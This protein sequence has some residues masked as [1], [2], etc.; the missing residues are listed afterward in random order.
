MITA[1]LPFPCVYGDAT[2]D[3]STQ[4]ARIE[5]LGGCTPPGAPRT[6]R[7]A[8]RRFTPAHLADVSTLVGDAAAMRFVGDGQPLDAVA[9]ERWLGA[10]IRSADGPGGGLWAIHHRADGAFVGY[11]GIELG[12][13]TGEP[14]LTYAL[15][16]PWWRRG[17]GLEAAGA[18][19][20]LAGR[21][22]P[23]LFATVDPANEA[24]LRIL[25]RLGFVVTHTAPDVH[26][27]TTVFLRRI[28]QDADCSVET[29]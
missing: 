6:A 3:D 14:E 17:L 21:S 19:L 4:V 24:S 23:T 28:R 11:C 1:A 15:N 16:P 29:T 8:F 25:Q 13:D 27:L 18:V 12:E 22:L 7:L 20:A 5:P 2:V 10:A 26:G 9:A